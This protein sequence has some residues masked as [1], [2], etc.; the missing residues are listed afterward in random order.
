MISS[1]LEEKPPSCVCLGSFTSFIS[2]TSILLRRPKNYGLRIGDLFSRL[3]T[4][5]LADLVIL[6]D[7]I[8][9]SFQTL[10]SHLR[11]LL[12]FLR[13]FQFFLL[14]DDF[15]FLLRDLSGECYNLRL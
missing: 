8:A 14:N 10:L 7:E 12:V 9:G 2:E 13:F 11:A 5:F 15:S 1:F 4:F 3:R 6:Q